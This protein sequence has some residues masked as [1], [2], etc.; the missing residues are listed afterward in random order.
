MQK[1][2]CNCDATGVERGAYVAARRALQFKL[3]HTHSASSIVSAMA[4]KTQLSKI[5]AITK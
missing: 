4:R 1:I 3:W 5:V 2:F